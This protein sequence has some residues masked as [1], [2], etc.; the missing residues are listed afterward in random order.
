MNPKIIALTIAS[1]L[2]LSCTDKEKEAEDKALM[3][4]YEAQK[5]V[6]SDLEFT[7]ERLQRKVAEKQIKDPSE[8]IKKLK[9]QIQEVANQRAS[10]KSEIAD[11]KAKKKAAETKL[12]D[13]KRK[14][15]IR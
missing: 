3:K 6:L 13:Y 15:P 10:F 5:E 2:L 9:D 12:A 8:E 14:Y 7:I 1:S 11:L 4:K